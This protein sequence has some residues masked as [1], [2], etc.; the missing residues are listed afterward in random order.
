M[1]AGLQ[2]QMPLLL[3]M[4]QE[5]WFLLVEYVVVHRGDDESH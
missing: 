3:R 2:P 5:P 1:N 4:G